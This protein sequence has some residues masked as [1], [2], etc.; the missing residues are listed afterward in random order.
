VDALSLPYTGT[1]SVLIDPQ[2]TTTGSV[3]VTLYDVSNVIGTVASGNPVTVTA[4]TPG[5]NGRFTF[6]GLAG[7]KVSLQ[8]ANSTYIGCP[9]VN[10]SIVKPDGDILAS[11]SISA[12]DQCYGGGWMDSQTLPTSGTY[13]LLIDPQGAATGDV[14]AIINI[15]SDI[16]GSITPETPV[17]VATTIPGQNALLSFSG[18][19]GQ[20]VSVELANST[21]IDSSW[22]FSAYFVAPDG[23][24]SLGG[25]ILC[26]GQI[27]GLMEV[28][29]EQTLPTTG[30]YT[31]LI[32]PL[33]PQTGSISLLMHTFFDVTGTIMLGSP[34]AV[35]IT[36]PGQDAK[37]SYSGTAGQAVNLHLTNSTSPGCFQFGLLTATGSQLGTSSV[38]GS[39]SGSTGVMTLP[40][41]GTYT[42][43][44][45]SWDASSTGSV[46]VTL[47]SQ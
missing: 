20:R 45:Y 33:G 31:L 26:C 38:C 13:T 11:T 21:Y 46:T 25:A 4:T 30:T 6:S 47:N 39:N 18:T 22:D 36:V 41:N 2:G 44:V 5:Q 8:L 40:A 32:K 3:T 37:L 27:G 43:Y 12:G 29:Y 15:F 9:A 1:Y 17:T 19:A 34:S 24:Q 10:G 14:T 35:T 16:T 42:V 7:Q 28:P 23:T